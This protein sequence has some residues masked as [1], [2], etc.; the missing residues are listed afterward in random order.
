MIAVAVTA[1]S[2]TD[3]KGLARACGITCCAHAAVC[4]CLGVSFREQSIKGIHPTL[5]EGDA[6]L[7]N[8]LDPRTT[9]GKK[10]ITQRELQLFKLLGTP[11]MTDP[12]SLCNS[13]L[14][15]SHVRQACFSARQVAFADAHCAAILVSHTT[16]VATTPSDVKLRNQQLC[17]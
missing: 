3:Q 8:R 11:P 2:V 16:I 13:V 4:P 7:S 12:N 17:C 10:K 6:M 1:A 14:W 9:E 5:D 15:V